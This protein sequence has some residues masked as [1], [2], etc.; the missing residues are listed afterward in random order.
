MSAF[1]T[2]RT[3]SAEFC[4]GAQMALWYSLIVQSL[5]TDVDLRSLAHLD[6]ETDNTDPDLVCAIRARAGRESSHTSWESIMKCTF[7]FRSTHPTR[8]IRIN[9]PS[10]NVVDFRNKAALL[11]S[12]LLLLLV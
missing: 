6:N 10:E 9:P 3:F 1:G 2:K 7:R 5:S 11:C 4:C 8:T 12:L